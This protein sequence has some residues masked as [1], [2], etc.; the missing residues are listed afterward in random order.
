MRSGVLHGGYEH[1]TR[2]NPIDESIPQGR[3]GP[4]SNGK[5]RALRKLFRGRETTGSLVMIRGKGEIDGKEGYRCSLS[6]A[7]YSSAYTR[8]FESRRT[9]LIND[10]FVGKEGYRCADYR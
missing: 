3:G 10:F 6:T 2:T 9:T 4:A 1:R 5:G 8:A 7:Q